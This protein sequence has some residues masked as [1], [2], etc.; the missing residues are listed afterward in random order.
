[1]SNTMKVIIGGAAALALGVT[2][3]AVSRAEGDERGERGERGQAVQI[4][5]LPAPVQQTVQQ[6]LQGGSVQH[7]EKRTREGRTLFEVRSV[8]EGKATEMLIGEDGRLLRS[9]APGEDDDD[10]D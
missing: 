2:V 4:A 10:D 5:D 3:L 8:R 9:G 6:Q 1:M 7:V